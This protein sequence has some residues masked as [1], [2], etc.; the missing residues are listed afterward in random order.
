LA[1]L[2]ADQKASYTVNVD[3]A[4]RLLEACRRGDCTRIINFSTQSAKIAV[5]GVYG[6][7]KSQGDAVLQESELAVTTLYASLVYGEELQG[8]FGSLVRHIK[9]LPVIP[10][11]GDGQ[12]LSA[13]LYVGDA[14]AAVEACLTREITVGRTYDLGGPDVVAFD[15]LLDLLCDRLGVKRRKVHVPYRMALMAAR[16]L[17]G[18]FP[19]PP[20]TVSNVLGSNQN[21]AMDLPTMRHH[22]GLRPMGLHTGLGLLF[23]G[24]I[25]AHALP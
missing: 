17:A 9:R 18:I 4:H 10:V 16:L 6:M 1:A 21:T 12:W 14:A 23:P 13:P 19:N 24:K 5:R 8:A 15:E 7:S 20:L 3:G 25:S 2:T 11:L 22:L